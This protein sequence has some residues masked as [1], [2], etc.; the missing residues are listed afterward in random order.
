MLRRAS[1]PHLHLHIHLHLHRDRHLHLHFHAKATATTT[2]TT[3]A[4]ASLPAPRLALPH[5]CGASS[6]PSAGRPCRTASIRRPPFEPST[7]VPVTFPNSHK[8]RAASKRLL[9]SE[10]SSGSSGCLPRHPVKDK[11][12]VQPLC[13]AN[14][15]YS[16]THPSAHP[17]IRPSARRRLAATDCRSNSS[18]ADQAP[19]S[20]S[21][22]HGV[23]LSTMVRRGQP[24]RST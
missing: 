1:S 13:P 18:P 20:G 7:A 4:T 3:T 11:H 16:P 8:C 23:P 10:D 24:T 19:G 17:P 2:A 22:L 21:L 9:A 5:R 14:R 15:V 6:H 12:T